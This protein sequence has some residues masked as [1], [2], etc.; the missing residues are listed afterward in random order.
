MAAPANQLPNRTAAIAGP[1]APRTAAAGDA[2]LVIPAPFVIRTDVAAPM[3]VQ[4]APRGDARAARNRRRHAWPERCSSSRAMGNVRGRT[5]A[6]LAALWLCSVAACDRTDRCPDTGCE[7]LDGDAGVDGPGGGGGGPVIECHI[8][9][10]P[11]GAPVRSPGA[12]IEVPCGGDLQAALY[13]A[14]RGDTIVLEAQSTCPQGY[15]SSGAGGEGFNLTNESP[16]TDYITITTSEAAALPAGRLRS[17]DDSKLAL[18]QIYKSPV[19]FYLRRGSHHYRL[20]GLKITNWED[21]G[22]DPGYAYFL[23]SFIDTEAGSLETSPHHLIVDHCWIQP[24]EE[25]TNPTSVQRSAARA[26]AFNGVSFVLQHSL[27]KGFGG[28]YRYGTATNE[29][30]DSAAF[31]GLIWG[32]WHF[33]DNHLEAFFNTFAFGGGGFSPRPENTGEVL[34]TPAPTLTSATLS[35]VANLEVGDAI[36]F[37]QP[38]IETAT[39][40]GSIGAGGDVAVTVTARGIAGGAPRTLLVAVAAGDDAPTVAAKLRAALAA[41]TEIAAFATVTG[42]GANVVL[43]SRWLTANDP[44]F[45]VE[46]AGTTASGL[47]AS[48][49]SADTHPGGENANGFV[50]TIDPSSGA[51]TFST[52]YQYRPSDAYATPMPPVS[53]TVAAWRGHQL[54]CVEI[55]RNTIFK[56]PKFKIPG[57]G[58]P[59]G[60]FEIKNANN[61]VIDG[62]VWA[63][64]PTGLA[65][66]N[67]NQNSSGP[68]ATISN[69]RITNNVM[70]DFTDVLSVA[71]Y[72]G[73]PED[74]QTSRSTDWTIANNL[75][76]GGSVPVE[77]GQYKLGQF[78]GVT[79]FSFVHNTMLGNRVA[80]VT[81]N[82]PNPGFVMRDNVMHNGEYGMGCG[83]PSGNLLENCWPA[84]QFTGNVV[85]DNRS[86]RTGDPGHPYPSGNRYPDSTD[87]V[88]F[89]GSLDGSTIASYTLGAASAF[90]ATATD[91]KD[92]GIDLA[93]L[94]AAQAMP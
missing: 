32:D 29:L 1:G 86:D 25:T 66:L 70:L 82:R 2:K 72:A 62:N 44:E 9:G 27:V 90:R 80:L 63:G 40:A 81:S 31:L 19:G 39:I 26:I 21:T 23:Q 3:G 46:I 30:I 55:T 88:G 34:A 4:R 50:E 79:N 91:G 20:Q 47:A 74:R 60:Y 42:D 18:V 85:I 12:R 16:G 35:S 56:D 11:I 49:V 36:T 58:G 53:G 77:I 71:G 24:I 75:F 54:E 59:K 93:A 33:V 87:E 92:P 51:I 43:V 8:G 61:L 17:T 68:W 89:A 76:L 13:A 37:P 7:T 52:T 6:V 83:S 10:E 67:G 65:F 84:I 78:D 15:R 73:S 5:A 14:A 94:L 38:Q 22:A 69:V 64:Y 48:P 28:R 45:N 41:N 57:Y